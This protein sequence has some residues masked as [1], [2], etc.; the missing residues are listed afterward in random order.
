VAQA[1]IAELT[2]L[3]GYLQAALSDAV[4]G[5]EVAF[6]ELNID[7]IPAQIVRVVKFLRDDPRSKFV[8]LIDICG[9]DYPERAPRFNVVYHLLSLHNNQRI[10]LRVPADGQTPVPSIIE[11]HPC[12]NWFERET[13]DMYGVLF[14]G[15]PDLRRIL[16]PGDWVGHPLRKDYPLR[17][18]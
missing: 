11:I 13:F 2:D 7:V 4:T 17:G 16:M 15:H 3:G 8:Q 14:S 1:T 18:K 5:R 6:G 9:V 12:A 10:R